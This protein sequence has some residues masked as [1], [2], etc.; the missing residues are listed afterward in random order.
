MKNKYPEEL[1]EKMI[2]YLK[3]KHPEKA[4]RERAIAVLDEMKVAQK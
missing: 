1:I 2:N 4:T 3:I